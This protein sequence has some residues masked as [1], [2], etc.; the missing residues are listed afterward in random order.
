MNG[1]HYPW[2]PV[3]FLILLLLALSIARVLRR[4]RKIDQSLAVHIQ[5]HTGPDAPR[6]PQFCERCRDE[7]GR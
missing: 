6:F 3:F 7:L 2:A 5:Y 4:P 1:Y